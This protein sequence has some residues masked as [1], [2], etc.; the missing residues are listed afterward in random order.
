MKK[1]ASLFA[2][3]A[4]LF[5]LTVTSVP[6]TAEAQQY[7]KRCRTLVIT[8]L[9][10]LHYTKKYA[11]R[12]AIRA[13]QARV[14]RRYGRPYTNPRLAMFKKVSCWLY[15]RRRGVWRCMAEAKPC[16]LIPAY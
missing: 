4:A 7:Y 16:R 6:T 3:F 14:N 8:G 10:P 2:V 1:L 13:W 12:D 9:S 11:K 5:A 15:D